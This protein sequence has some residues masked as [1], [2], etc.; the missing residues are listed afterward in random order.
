[1][2]NLGEL[3]LSGEFISSDILLWKWAFSQ[4]AIERA[5]ALRGLHLQAKAS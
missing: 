4:V 3:S 2:L 5:R 1:M